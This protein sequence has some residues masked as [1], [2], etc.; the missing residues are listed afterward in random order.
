MAETELTREL[1]AAVRG[2]RP[3]IKSTM[4]TIRWAEEVQ[5]GSG[6]V[7]V[8]RF[9]DYVAGTE[10]IKSCP[11]R[12][13]GLEVCPEHGVSC[14]MA[15]EYV[16]D[17]MRIA[18][19]CFEVKITKSDFRSKNGHNFVGN[20]NYYVIPKEL[21]KDVEELVP[22]GIGLLVRTGHLTLR[23]RKAP[24]WREVA[25]ED[26]NLYLYNALKKWVAQPWWELSSFGEFGPTW[27][28]DEA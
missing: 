16:V 21:L 27:K 17:S 20:L 22:E 4:R 1:K 12:M 5:V 14:P 28:E 8:I 11:Q 19:T 3:L 10:R 7:D 18:T 26:L 9:E 13:K 25:P 23:E 15:R 24:Q 2:F 6:Y